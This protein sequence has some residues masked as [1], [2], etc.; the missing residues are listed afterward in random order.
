MIQQDVIIREPWEVF[1][2]NRSR[3]TN[4]ITY[5]AN[6]SETILSNAEKLWACKGVD[7]ELEDD[8][9]WKNLE[10]VYDERKPKSNMVK[11]CD[12]FSISYEN[13]FKNWFYR[14]Y[15]KNKYSY[16]LVGKPKRIDNEELIIVKN[17][18]KGLRYKPNATT[19]GVFLNEAQVNTA[20]KRGRSLVQI[21]L[22]DNL[23]PKAIS[24]YSSG[25]WKIRKGQVTFQARQTA[26]EDKR[27]LAHWIAVLMATMGYLPPYK[28]HNSDQSMVGIKTA[29][30]NNIVF[31]ACEEEVEAHDRLERLVVKTASEVL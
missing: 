21:A 22:I 4:V 16:E 9:H 6:L 3:R 29:G 30:S 18:I 20:V 17:K 24:E 14:N 27:A 26:L 25:L 8:I 5:S 10:L 28:K 7:G 11:F 31:I 13:T 19:V 15:R 2:I 1:E 23:S 12:L